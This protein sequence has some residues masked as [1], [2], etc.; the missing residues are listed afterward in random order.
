VAAIWCG[1][2]Q[3]LAAFTEVA[4]RRPVSTELAYSTVMRML[5]RVTAH[6]NY[7]SATSNMR[8]RIDRCVVEARQAL[9]FMDGVGSRGPEAQQVSKSDHGPVSRRCATRASNLHSI[10]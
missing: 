1:D 5:D 9:E 4:L 3:R 8:T 6:P 7:V 2:R 10:V